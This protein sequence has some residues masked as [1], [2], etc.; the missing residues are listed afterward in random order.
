[1][2]ALLFLLLGLPCVALAVDADSSEQPKP[3][4]FIS[5]PIYRDTD[6]G[7]KSGCWLAD[8]PATGVR[9]DVTEGPT[10]PQLG[11][12]ILV[13]GRISNEPNACGGVVLRPVRTAVLDATCPSALIPAEGYAGRRFVLPEKVMQPTWQA[14]PVPTSPYTEK[15]FDIVF[16]FGNDFLIYQYSELIL[17]DVATYAK[18][19]RAKTVEVTAYAATKPFEVSGTRLAEPLELAKARAEM[20]AEAL[21]R[22]GIAREQLKVTWHG[23]P[24]PLD[25]PAPT[26][27]ESTKRRVTIRVVPPEATKHRTQ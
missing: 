24:L 27:P 4:A 7:R 3:M 26:G 17:E 13:E 8:D 14:R 10:K 19:S 12:Q 2:R 6:A 16:D 5:C 18:A 9:Y 25:G 21:R 22:L 11:R 23:D 15:T 1:M 20:T